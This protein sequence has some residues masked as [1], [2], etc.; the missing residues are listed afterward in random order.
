MPLVPQ[1]GASGA[2]GAN[3]AN[4]H[5]QPRERHYASEYTR[6]GKSWMDSPSETMRGLGWGVLIVLALGVLHPIFGVFFASLW[7]NMMPVSFARAFVDRDTRTRLFNAIIGEVPNVGGGGI[8][9]TGLSSH[10]CNPLA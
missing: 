5:A 6:R 10:F 9:G 7:N 1:N 4:G 3:G 2:N 8:N